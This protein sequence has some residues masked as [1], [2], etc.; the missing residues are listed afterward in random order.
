M[1]ATH[2]AL[3]ALQIAVWLHEHQPTWTM[4]VSANDRT[5]L[6]ENS[7]LIIADE[8]P[9]VLE[10]LQKLPTIKLTSHK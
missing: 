1:K 5:Q 3:E 9:K 6:R 7:R 4:S 10:Y 8:T 2:Y